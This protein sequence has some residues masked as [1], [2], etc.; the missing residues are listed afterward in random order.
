MEVGWVLLEKER[1]IVCDNYINVLYLQFQ[2]S[3]YDDILLYVLPGIYLLLGFVGYFVVG[4]TRTGFSLQ[5]GCWFFGYGSKC[6]E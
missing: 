2:N 3:I 5:L 1:E 4:I 6:K